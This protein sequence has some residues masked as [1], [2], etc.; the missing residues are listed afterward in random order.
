M[1]CG[2]AGMLPGSGRAEAR[3]SAGEP[4][5]C[6][7]RRARDTPKGASGQEPRALRRLSPCALVR[8]AVVGMCIQRQGQRK[9]EP[10]PRRGTGD[11]RVGVLERL[12]VKRA[13]GL[14]QSFRAT[15]IAGT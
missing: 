10:E 2:G 4:A 6:Y 3:A 11:A 7:V 8:R 9:V 15:S 12:V 5:R 1:A 14:S 13:A